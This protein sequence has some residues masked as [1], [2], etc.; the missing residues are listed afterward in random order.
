MEYREAIKFNHFYHLHFQCRIMWCWHYARVV[1]FWPNLVG[2]LT[3]W[4]KLLCILSSCVSHWWVKSMNPP[5][6]HVTGTDMSPRLYEDTWFR[7]SKPRWRKN[8]ETPWATSKP[9][10]RM[11]HLTLKS[12]RHLQTKIQSNPTCICFA[13]H[14]SLCWIQANR[15]YPI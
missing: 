1:F 13:R 12:K 11:H 15:C 10:I 2:V 8:E 5:F 3:N 7:Q 14:S 4:L 6:V 9:A